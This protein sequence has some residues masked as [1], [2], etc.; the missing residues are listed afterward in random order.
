MS[1]DEMRTLVQKHIAAELAMD[2][3]AVMETLVENPRYEFHPLRLSLE[4]K[5]NI[6][7]FYREHFDAFFPLLKSHVLINECWDSHSVCMEYDI[8]LKPPHNSAQPHRIMVALT[9]E[10]S[11]L[12]GERFYVKT[13]LAQLIAG[14]CFEKFSEF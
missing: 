4:G 3:N 7:E 12:V 11:Q 6:R 13:E 2:L 10:G 5:E 14:K 8:Y 1:T 9:R